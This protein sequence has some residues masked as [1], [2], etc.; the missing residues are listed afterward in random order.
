MMNRTGWATAAA[1]ALTLVGAQSAHA[2]CITY[3][4]IN[5]CS[6]G[7]AHLS[8][9]NGVLTATNL[10]SNAL[11]GVEASF[12]GVTHWD[13]TMNIPNP[14]VGDRAR[15]SAISHGQT[16]ARADLRLTPG[17]L[18]VTTSFTGGN[19]SST[20]EIYD[21][22]VL[23]NTLPMPDDGRG[24]IIIGP[25]DFPPTDPFPDPWPPIIDF[26]VTALGACSYGFRFQGGVTV[27]VGSQTFSATNV[28]IRENLSG[29]QYPYVSFDRMQIQTNGPTLEIP[30]T[31]VSN[32]L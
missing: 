9:S 12:S 27:T 24:P 32:G 8:I 25:I 22:G 31:N 4:G 3:Q 6:I 23:A 20:V 17:G 15:F 13:A 16:T 28:V 5:H 1:V 7:S 26:D 14:S 11:D 18:V 30:D 10:G 21:H 29:S 19:G 2:N